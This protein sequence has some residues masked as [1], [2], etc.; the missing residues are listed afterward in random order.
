MEKRFFLAFFLTVAVMIAYAHIAGRS[1]SPKTEPAA[2]VE[3]QA[4]KVTPEAKT[5]SPYAV[6]F[7]KQ[8]AKTISVGDFDITY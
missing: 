5:D 6:T 4:P 2:A 3:T 1:V 8:Y 7:D